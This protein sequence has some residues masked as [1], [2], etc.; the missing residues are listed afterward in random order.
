MKKEEFEAAFL[1]PYPDQRSLFILYCH[2]GSKAM[3]AF[4]M[5]AVNGYHN[6]KL[7]HGGAAEWFNLPL[8]IQKEKHK[9]PQ[10]NKPVQFSG[11]KS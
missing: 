3:D 1:L 2:N 10:P 9:P 5:L 6:V 8:Q 7:Y 11:P 4:R